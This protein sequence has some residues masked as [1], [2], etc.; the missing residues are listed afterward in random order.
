[1]L[2]DSTKV[3][4]AIVLAVGC[5]LD[6]TRPQQAIW[7]AMLSGS[8]A[9]ATVAGD[10]AAVAND[11]RTVVGVTVTGLP[12]GTYAWRVREGDCDAPG[13]VVGA[14]DAYPNLAVVPHE[15]DPEDPVVSEGIS[16]EARIDAPMIEGG[17]YHAAVLEADLSDDV[18][19]GDFVQR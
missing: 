6:V 14:N 5:G 11:Q 4:L 16:A 19:C 15:P 13:A 9:Y 8:P 1:M 17:R 3:V 12:E 2:N 7:E 18:A 10:A